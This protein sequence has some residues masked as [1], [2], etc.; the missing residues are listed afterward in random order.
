MSG[1][2]HNPAKWSEAIWAMDAHLNPNPV[3]ESGDGLIILCSSLSVLR[4]FHTPLD[5]L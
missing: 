5:G 2:N 3:K 1:N 4:D